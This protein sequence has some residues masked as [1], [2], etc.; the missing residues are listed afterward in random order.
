[1]PCNSHAK[2]D[3]ATNAVLHGIAW[4]RVVQEPAITIDE[5]G[6]LRLPIPIFGEKGGYAANS[7]Q[8]A[9][10]LAFIR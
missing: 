1:M 5:R 6:Y 9:D 3:L 8:G 10:A 2:Q 4:A 7:V